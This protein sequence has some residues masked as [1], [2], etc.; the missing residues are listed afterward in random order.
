MNGRTFP[1][2]LLGALA[3]LTVLTLTSPFG[4][5]LAPDSMS[6]LGGARSL[7]RTGRLSIPM[8][9]ALDADS[10]SPLQHFPPGFPVVLALPT[11]L[12]I[13]PERAARVLEA[14]SAGATV[15]GVTLL[16]GAAATTAAG[17]LAG[18][19]LL[20]TPAF[21]EDHFI[22]LSEPLFLALLVLTLGLMVRAPDRPLRAGLAAAVATLV[23]Y[24]GI[25]LGAACFVGALARPGAARARLKGAA[26]AG[27]PTVLAFVGWSLASGG[28]RPYHL[29]S[30]FGAGL[31]QGAG[32]IA[33]WLTPS[34]EAPAWRAAAALVLLAGLAASL[35]RA[36]RRADARG[37]PRRTLGVLGLLAVCYSGVL[38]ASRAFADEEIPLDGRILSPLLL[39]VEVGFAVAIGACWREWRRAPR[40]VAAALIGLWLAGALANDAQVAIGLRENG[41]D[42]ESPEWQES[43]LAGWLRAEGRGYAIYSNNPAVVYFLTERPSR[44]L[45][46][47]GD[48]ATLR[49]LAT[50]LAGG[51]AAVV[52][53]QDSLAPTMPAGTVARRLGLHEAGRSGLG[54]VFVTP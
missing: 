25:G 49:G 50:S 41:W 48:T 12:G 6:Y 5:A 34:L 28:A 54:V 42:Y 20:V 9:E 44:L 29:R 47:P 32:T 35:A 33:A 15:A 13:A 1:A 43:P 16:A 8:S 31:R 23:R 7:V 18:A 46:N 27:L 52:G 4:A 22:I 40:I 38:L 24:V 10:T 26:L 14:L 53:F 21:L 51:R 2:G 11:A 3:V 45:P 17:V 37:E 19:I 30:G 36:W 39:L